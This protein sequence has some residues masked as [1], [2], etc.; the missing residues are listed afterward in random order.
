MRSAAAKN[1][2]LPHERISVG[3]GGTRVNNL[4]HP[5]A[6]CSGQRATR[7]PN[8]KMKQPLGSDLPLMHCVHVRKTWQATRCCSTVGRRRDVERLCVTINDQHVRASPGVPIGRSCRE[9]VRRV[10]AKI[11]DKH[12]V[13]VQT[14]VNGRF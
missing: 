2:Q 3:G 14:A 10:G 7:A 4:T 12:R 5:V 11:T 8:G 6:I 1:H 13:W 9:F